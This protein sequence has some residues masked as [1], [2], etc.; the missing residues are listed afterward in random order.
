[1]SKISE[2]NLSKKKS[3][4]KNIL[5]RSLHFFFEIN[6][7]IISKIIIQIFIYVYVSVKYGY[8]CCLIFFNEIYLIIVFGI[9]FCDKLPLINKPSGLKAHIRLI[10]H[11]LCS[12]AILLKPQSLEIP[13][14]QL[15]RSLYPPTVTPPLQHPSPASSVSF[16][17]VNIFVLSRF[18]I[19]YLLLLHVFPFGN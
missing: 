14:I 1:M 18:E 15:R 19:S 6:V 17:T 11:L 2:E 5:K 12:A 13:L 9:C 3:F 16:E 7:K 10:I 4:L 8:N